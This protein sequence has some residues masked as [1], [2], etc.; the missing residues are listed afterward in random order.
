MRA[1][2][3]FFFARVPAAGEL[4]ARTGAALT[5]I[6]LLFTTGHTAPSGSEL[7]RTDLVQRALDVARMLHEL[8]PEDAEVAGLLG[9]IQLTDSR[10]ATRLDPAGHLTLLSDQDRSRWDREAIESGCALARLAVQGRPPGRFALEAA[11]AAVHAEAPNWEA[12]DWTEIVGLYDLLLQRW[13]SPVV[14]LN[15]AAAIGFALGP[16]AGLEALDK[17]ATEPQLAGY[18]YL[19]AAR[20]D[21]LRRLGRYEE[22]Q[23]AYVEALLLTDNEVE[24]DYLSGRVTALKQRGKVEV[25]LLEGT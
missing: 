17:L 18:G 10:R 24:R 21:A 6:H 3:I 5:V 22:A 9:L 7:V 8:L 14:A 20:A 4:S 11:I 2:A 12:T 16:Q 1:A 19:P 13:P 23:Q 15:R 25:R